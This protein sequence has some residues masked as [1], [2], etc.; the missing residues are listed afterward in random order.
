MNISERI[1]FLPIV[2]FEDKHPDMLIAQY[3]PN[4]AENFSCGEYS[5]NTE[6]WD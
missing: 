3:K 1:G 2:P 6:C 4:A 5:M